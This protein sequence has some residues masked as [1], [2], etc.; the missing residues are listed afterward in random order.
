ME[1]NMKCM[2]ESQLRSA[3]RSYLE[4][5]SPTGASRIVEELGIERGAARIDLALITDRLVGFEIKSDQDTFD[6]LSNQIHAYNRVF[7]EITLVTGPA[8][9]DDA[10]R[11]LPPWWGM[12]TAESDSAGP[13]RLHVVREAQRNPLQEAISVAMLLWKA[14]AIEVLALHAHHI[15]SR[16]AS[17]K[18]HAMLAE[19]VPLNSLQRLV[20]TKLTARETWRMPVRSEPSD[21]SSHPA[22][23]SIDCPM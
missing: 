13:I 22:A 10:L 15:P 1:P 21:D 11:L 14:E 20:A 9:L 3:L 17:A 8:L 2:T 6:R 18:I 4:G 7:D 16:W 23:M 19:V 5:N 12:M